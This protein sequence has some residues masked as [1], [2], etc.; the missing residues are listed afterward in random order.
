MNGIELSRLVKERSPETVRIVFSGQADTESVIAAVN[1]G[2]VYKFLMKSWFRDDLRQNIRLALD[3]YALAER[4]R[5]LDVLLAERNRELSEMNEELERKVEA[6]GAEL[7]D[8]LDRLRKHCAGLA[9]AFLNMIALY[10][11]ELSAHCRRTGLV[12]KAL[13]SACGAT[14]EL[15]D[16]IE[17]AATLH[18]VGKVALGIER[19]GRLSKDEEGRLMRLHPAAGA[20]VLSTVPGFE[21]IAA[22]IRG[23]H[24]RY[25]G[26]GYPDAL[27]GEGICFG[28]RLIAVA[29][30]FDRLTLLPGSKIPRSLQFVEESILRLS[31]LELDP[32]ALKIFISSGLS[33]DL[34]ARLYGRPQAKS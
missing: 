21:R 11:E 13:A 29:D 26:Q 6:R 28:A 23:H 17:S 5:E 10:S 7:V 33:S 34:H 32:V 20:K 4:N 8:A 25:D 18:D 31:G 14:P 24:E 27:V 12:A 1:E 19:G 30:R 22:M 9:D 16:E 2:S 3:H 15:A